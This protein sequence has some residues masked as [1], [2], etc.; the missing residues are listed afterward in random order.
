MLRE[1]SIDWL[2]ILP[3]WAVAIIVAVLAA[4]LAHGCSLLARKEAPRRWIVL[5]AGLR[6]TAIGLFALCLL[7][8]AVSYLRNVVRRPELLALVDTSQSMAAK[9]S[10]A[11]PT[12]L[13]ETLGALQRTELLSALGKK[14]DVHWFAFDRQAAPLDPAQLDRLKPTGDSTH[15][16]ESLASAFDL[17]NAGAQERSTPIDV[18]RMLLVSDGHDQ[19][20]EDL[21]DMAAQFGVIV[22]VLPAGKSAPSAET[23]APQIARVQSAPRVLLGSETR[24]LVTLENEARQAGEFTLSLAEDGDAVLTQDIQLA[25]GDTE[26]LVNVAYRPTEAGLKRYEFALAPKAAAKPQ[27]EP[28]GVNVQVLDDKIEVLVLEDRW[29]WEFKYLRRVLED[30]PSFNFTAM[31]A[32]GAGA[33]VQFGEPERKVAL[34]GFPNSRS[35]LDWF[36]VIVLGDVHPARWP[37]RLSGALA[38]AVIE[39]GK[40]LVVVAGPSLGELAQMPELHTLLPVELSNQ[41]ATPL[42]GP[43]ELQITPEGARSALF[44]RGGG[45]SPIRELPVIDRIYPPLR[46]R[47]A[48]SVLV[49]AAGEAN[50]AGR[51]IAVAEHT[52]GRGRVLYIGADSLYKWQTLSTPDEQNQTIYSKFWQQTLRSLTPRRTTSAGALFVQA[53]RTRYEVGGRIALRADVAEQAESDPPALEATVVLPDERR[54]P[55]P[56]AADPTEVGVYRAEFDATLPGQYRVSV[57]AQSEGQTIAE[58]STAIE[59]IPARTELADTGV[60]RSAL[61]RIAARTGGK[62]IDLADP[63]SWPV[64]GEQNLTTIVERHTVNLWENFSLLTVL[65]LVLGCDWLLRLMKGFV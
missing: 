6:V 56:L 27:A 57:S 14:F 16:A 63:Q 15:Y 32:R 61:S 40:S 46:K 20:S 8:P 10:P 12:R 36:D 39:G 3:P 19:G 22:D 7:Q 48:A 64:V 60:D 25:A 43:I 51:L 17:L 38:D 37:K 44:T 26:R 31:L 45:E 42:E 33:H 13:E 9:D 47:P 29:R 59:A 4:L 23:K 65:C 35:E 2:P 24:F 34:G 1:P 54:L 30:D 21:A 53:D 28:Y 18:S 58:A 11:G 49:E 41:S 62:V 55:L 50:A 5:L 52:V